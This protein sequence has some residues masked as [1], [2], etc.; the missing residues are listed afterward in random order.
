MPTSE[1]TK[2]LIAR[3]FKGLME[4]TPFARISIGDIARDSQVSRNTFYYHFKDKYDILHWIF[5]TELEPIIRRADLS[6]RWG[7]Q[8]RELSRYMRENRRFYNNAL[9]V[10]GPEG[11]E[12]WLFSIYR[13]LLASRLG[14]LP[15]GEALNGEEI[16]CI[17]GFLAHGLTGEF[18]EWMLRGMADELGQWLT[19]LERI[20]GGRS[21][22]QLLQPQSAPEERQEP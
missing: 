16:R 19:I 7:E 1:R 5:R 20:L 10:E 2:R 8:V 13:E 18:V 17:A 12:A 11:M 22:R 3:S 21:L 14:Q 6:G 9:Q 15:E 4:T